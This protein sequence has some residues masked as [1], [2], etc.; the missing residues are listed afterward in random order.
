[1]QSNCK[2]IKL[3]VFSVMLT[4]SGFMFSNTGLVCAGP[5]TQ[6]GINGYVGQDRRHAAP[7]DSDAVINPIFKH[8]A[9][10]YENYAPTPGVDVGWQTPQ[11]TLGPVTGNIAD[12]ASLGDL[13]QSQINQRVSPGEI[14]LTFGIARF[15][16]NLRLAR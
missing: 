12:V 1:M 5:Y 6:P 11:E 15:I 8:W 14:T 3:S 4:L 2:L 7:G 16:Q 10:G 13:S 9:S